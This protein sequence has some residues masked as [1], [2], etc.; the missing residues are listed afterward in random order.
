MLTTS[1]NTIPPDITS[2]S[3]PDYSLP[4]HIVD[5]E[6]VPIPLVPV[7]A[8]SRRLTHNGVPQPLILSIDR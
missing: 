1:V 5:E 3:A 2:P 4:R 8:Q 7:G 6:G